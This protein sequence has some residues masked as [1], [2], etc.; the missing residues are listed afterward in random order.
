LDFVFVIWVDSHLVQFFARD[1]L[2]RELIT[3]GPYRYIRHP[4]YV[5]II[6]YRVVYA[7]I[8][9]SVLG[10]FMLVVFAIAVIRRIRV[11][12]NHMQSLFGDQ[13]QAYVR[14]TARLVPRLY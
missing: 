6:A 4:R 7:L 3:H 14:K 12:E 13:Y 11:E 1:K 2:D 8:F 9:A 10:W 5:A